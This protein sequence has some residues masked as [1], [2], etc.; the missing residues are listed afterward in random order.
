MGGS[1]WQPCLPNK[2]TDRSTRPYRL[3]IINFAFRATMYHPIYSLSPAPTRSHVP[4]A[5]GPREAINQCERVLQKQPFL[6][7]GSIVLSAISRIV[8]PWPLSTV[9][10]LPG[11]S[12]LTQAAKRRA[13]AQKNKNA[14][15]ASRKNMVK[16]EEVTVDE[17]SVKRRRKSAKGGDQNGEDLD[18]DS[19]HVL[20]PQKKRAF[21]S[22]SSPGQSP[23][24]K[25]LKSNSGQGG[26]E[27]VDNETLIRET[28]ADLK[29]LSGSWPG[30]RLAFY[31][32][33][34]AEAEDR[35]ESPGFENL[36]EE[37]K[38]SLANS[39]ASAAMLANSDNSS[40]SLK[41]VIT[42][43]DQQDAKNIKQEL[44]SSNGNQGKQENSKSTQSSKNSVKSQ[45]DEK[46]QQQKPVQERNYLESLIKIENEC[47]SIQSQAKSKNKA[48]GTDTL[49]S[50]DKFPTNGQ[51]YEP[52]FNELVDDS[53]NELEIDMS[54]ADDRNGKGDKQ[55]KKDNDDKKEGKGGKTFGNSYNNQ[56]KAEKNK[57]SNSPTAFTTPTSFRDG[58]EQP[59]MPSNNLDLQTSTIGPFPAGA[60]FVGY[61]P[62]GAAPV[63]RIPPE[64][65]PSTVCL[66]PLKPTT[67]KV[68]PEDVTTGVTSSKISVAS[69]E[70]PAS[71]QYTILQPAGA[72][73]RAASAIQ[74]VTREGVLGVPAV[75]STTAVVSSSQII[76]SA[77]SSSGSKDSSRSVG[78]LSPSAIGKAKD[79]R[80]RCRS[81]EAGNVRSN[82]VRLISVMLTDPRRVASY[83]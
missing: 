7:A 65:K 57:S 12:P 33:G 11:S 60:T 6:G 3:P 1:M 42:L 61:P 26:D 16:K 52:D 25:T 78:S 29:S 53:S 51:R 37:K 66:L 68:E 4:L 43:R 77:D 70:N 28:E 19:K 80:S 69:P 21:V 45:R 24:K 64:E 48:D 71:K 76:A 58:K 59:R 49:K 74:D 50:G 23:A 41:D 46:D 17:T 35:F 32:R 34:I 10:A 83:F 15:V 72:G 54:E 40:C 56:Q 36:F 62:S 47:A 39:S 13:E 67:T 73:S 44:R 27:N 75:S 22:N 18:Y 2:S 82:K 8:S 9:T 38:N 55:K 79:R 31:N 30:P 5:S 81:V 20:L 63:T 14:D